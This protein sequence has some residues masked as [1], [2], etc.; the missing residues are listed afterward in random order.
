M[1]LIIDANIVFAA[2]IKESLTADLI[3]SP[4]LDLYSPKFLFEEFEKYKTYLHEKTYRSP[5]DFMRY[6]AILKRNIHTVQMSVNEDSYIHA[7]EISPDPKD[8]LYFALALK[9]DLP[10]WTNDSRLGNQNE[11]QIIDTTELYQRITEIQK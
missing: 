7:K 4:K 2:L 10:I 5:E 8:A 6:L 11:I 1:Q 9:L 3:A